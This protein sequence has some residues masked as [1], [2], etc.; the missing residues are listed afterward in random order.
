METLNERDKG[1]DQT[2]ANT[3][4][5]SDDL[6]DVGDDT[7]LLES[8]GISKRVLLTSKNLAEDSSHDLSRSSLWKILNDEDSLWS[9]EWTNLLADL[10]DEILA[11]LWGV[12]GY[13]LEGDESVN[14]LSS[15]LIGDTDDSGL[16]DV[17]MGEESGLDLSS[18]QSVTR[19]VDDIINTSTDPVVSLVITSSAIT[20]EVV[21]L[22]DVEV[23]VKETLV[24]SPDGTGHRWPWVLDGKDTLD[25]VSLN[26]DTGDWVDDGWGD[27]KEWEGSGSWLGWGDTS[28]WGNDVGTGLRLPVSLYSC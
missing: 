6:D 13:I 12:L 22:V 21:S 3:L 18:G 24:G 1:K 16:S 8:G 9:S 11:G 2:R 19:D 15:E 28:E 23:G 26:L 27:T 10:E 14:G 5:G 25:I 4:G 7:W 17:W 20:S